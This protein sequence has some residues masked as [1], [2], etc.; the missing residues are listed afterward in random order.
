MVWF[1]VVSPDSHISNIETEA[2]SVS[3]EVLAISPEIHGGDA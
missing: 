3:T 1:Y 2:Q